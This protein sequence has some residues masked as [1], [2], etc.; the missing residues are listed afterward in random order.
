V[1]KDEFDG[2]REGGFESVMDFGYS[3]KWVDG[4]FQIDGIKA[5]SIIEDYKRSHSIVI[6][7]I[8]GI[9]SDPLIN[10]QIDAL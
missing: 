3:F 6:I 8:R 5:Q 2:H 7:E 1:L 10:D 9:L 4:V